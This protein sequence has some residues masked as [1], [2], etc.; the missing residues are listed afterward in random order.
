[1]VFSIISNFFKKNDVDY[2]EEFK[3]QQIDLLR[4]FK[5][6][7]LSHQDTYYTVAA[8]KVDDCLKDINKVNISILKI[9]LRINLLSRDIGALLFDKLIILDD[10]ENKI[11]SL[12]KELNSK[13]DNIGPGVGIGL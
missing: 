8:N 10:T 5:R 9:A 6:C 1:M 12:I 11:W 4:K 13:H 7:L 3:N 2:T